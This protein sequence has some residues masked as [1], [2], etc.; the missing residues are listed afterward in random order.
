ML[1]LDIF[2]AAV[3]LQAEKE[4]TY[5]FK[6]LFPGFEITL[7]FLGRRQKKNELLCKRQVDSEV[8][9]LK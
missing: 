2:Q 3:F 1:N 7:E 9:H 5:Q 8:N 4:Q 6:N